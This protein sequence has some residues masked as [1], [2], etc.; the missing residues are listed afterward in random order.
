MKEWQEKIIS[1]NGNVAF[2]FDDQGNMVVIDPDA[3][4]DLVPIEAEIAAREFLDTHPKAPRKS[5][6]HLANGKKNF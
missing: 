5:L 1:K 3:N 4:V 2:G 6:T